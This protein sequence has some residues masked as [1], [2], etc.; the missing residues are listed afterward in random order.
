VEGSRTALTNVVARGTIINGI[1]SLIAGGLFA[2]RNLVAAAMMSPTA[3]AVWTV[4]GVVLVTAMAL[5]GVGVVE[6]FVAERDRPA[7]EAFDDAFS[8]GLMFGALVA[9]I[10]AILAPLLT[11]AYDDSRLLLPLLAV[12]GLIVLDGVKFPIWWHY[13]ELRFQTQRSLML[14]DAAASVIFAIPLLVIGWDYWGLIAG[15]ALAS[16][17]STVLVWAISPHPR[18][19]RPTREMI[20]RYTSFGGPVLTFALVGIVCGHLGYMVVRHVGGLEALGWLGVAGFP[21][22]VSERLTAVLNQSVYP[23]LVRRGV[24]A[25]ERA[26]ELMQRTV[27][28][29]VAPLMFLIA[30]VAP[31]LLPA[32]IGEEWQNAG[33]LMA[34]VAATTVIRQFAFTFTV[35]VMSTG[36]TSVINRFSAIYVAAAVLVVIPATFA[37]G[38]IG[39]AATLPVVELMLAAERWRVVRAA[40]PGVNLFARMPVDLVYAA[41]PGVGALVAL[42][43]TPDRPWGERVALVVLLAFEG[44]LALVWR[45]R[46]LA[47][48]LLSALKRP[49]AAPEQA[50]EPSV[51]VPAAASL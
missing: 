34:V 5:R 27:F 2:V 9:V 43:I 20:R 19:K 1:A 31:W 22:V 40:L 26:T 30:A 36:T 50:P 38:M 16:C 18:A 4:A 47:G 29:G 28:A 48:T 13:R 32:A 41:L 21:F 17:V 42:L 14:F 45:H 33:Y 35:I 25:R 10:V 44:V 8:V 24:A 6:R 12:A 23:A 3:L 11:F 39:Y 15:A 51:G 7:R 46:A 37:F 49:P